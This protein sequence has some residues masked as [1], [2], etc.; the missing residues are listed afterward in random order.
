M[1][2][3]V[4]VEINGVAVP[5]EIGDDALAA[6]AVALPKPELPPPPEY[7]TVVEAAEILRAKPQRVYDLLSAR[8]LTRHK[9]GSRTLVERAELEAYLNHT[10]N[11]VNQ[12]RYDR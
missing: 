12:R 7:A 9:D 8:V 3:T 1:S 11:R 5:V 10:E 6:I 2:V 4:R